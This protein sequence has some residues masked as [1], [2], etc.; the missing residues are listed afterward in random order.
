[1]PTDVFLIGCEALV[2]STNKF[3][4]INFEGAGFIYDAER[5]T[6]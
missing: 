2:N 1:M 3:L 6:W 5:D 4:I